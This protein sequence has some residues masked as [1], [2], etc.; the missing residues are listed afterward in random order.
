MKK[1]SRNK[2]KILRSNLCTICLCCCVARWSRPFF[3]SDYISIY[4]SLS[5][6]EPNYFE[7]AKTEEDCRDM[8][9]EVSAHI[10]LGISSR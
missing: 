3:E 8:G 2:T 10:R 6:E 9:A 4:I 5:N 7:I 1:D